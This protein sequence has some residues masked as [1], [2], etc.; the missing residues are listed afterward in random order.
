MKQMIIVYSSFVFCFSK[1]VWCTY[2]YLNQEK[3]V[4]D[5]VCVLMPTA[6]ADVELLKHEK[7]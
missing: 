3:C 4:R 7:V 5:G 1:S 6:A 2:F